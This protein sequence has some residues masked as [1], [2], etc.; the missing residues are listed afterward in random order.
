M[1]VYKNEKY[2]NNFYIWCIQEH[3]NQYG[4]E[5]PLV[6]KSTMFYPA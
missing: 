3:P 1:Y 4:T 6:K 2:E 5:A